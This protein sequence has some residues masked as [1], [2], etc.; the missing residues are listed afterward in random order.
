MTTPSGSLSQKT[1]ERRTQKAWPWIFEK[2]HDRE[3]RRQLFLYEGPEEELNLNNDGAG[4]NFKYRAER[5]K[6]RREKMH[7]GRIR[8]SSWYKC[9]D[10]QSEKIFYL[11]KKTN[12]SSYN[13]P[14][15]L[16]KEEMVYWEW[17]EHFHEENG[18]FFYI[19]QVTGKSIWRVPCDIDEELVE[20][21]VKRKARELASERVCQ[22]LSSA[23]IELCDNVRFEPIDIKIGAK[24]SSKWSK[25]LFN[26][27]DCYFVLEGTIDK[28]FDRPPILPSQQDVLTEW[29]EILDDNTGIFF[30]VHRVYPFLSIWKVP[31]DIDLA[32]VIKVFSQD[33]VFKMIRDCLSSIEVEQISISGDKSSL[34]GKVASRDE[35]AVSNGEE[36]GID[37]LTEEYELKEAKEEEDTYGEEWEENEDYRWF[38][39]KKVYDQHIA[40]LEGRSCETD[41]TVS[42]ISTE[43]S[44]LSQSENG[45]NL[46]I[47]VVKSKIPRS[48]KFSYS[49]TALN[50]WHFGM[51]AMHIYKLQTHKTRQIMDISKWKKQ[52]VNKKTENF[53]RKLG[54]SLADNHSLRGLYAKGVKDPSRFVKDEDGKLVNLDEKY[55]FDE[56]CIELLFSDS[57]AF[58]DTLTFLDLSYNL[59][60]ERGS[61]ILFRS[62]KVNSRLYELDLT[63]CGIVAQA[64]TTIMKALAENSSLG[65]LILR[66]NLLQDDGAIAIFQALVRNHSLRHLDVA[67]NKIGKK[68]IMELGQAI[69]RNT[70]LQ[71]LRLEGNPWLHELNEPI[72]NRQVRNHTKITVK[73][74]DEDTSEHELIRSVL[75]CLVGAVGREDDA[76]LSSSKTESLFHYYRVALTEGDDSVFLLN[77]KE[78]PGK[79]FDPLEQIP[80]QIKILV[81]LM[82]D[83]V[84]RF[85]ENCEPEVVSTL[86]CIVD[87]VV[88]YD[89]GLKEMRKIENIHLE[90]T[91]VPEI[92]RLFTF[93]DIECMSET[94]VEEHDID[95]T[96]LIN[97][98]SDQLEEH[99]EGIKQLGNEMEPLK[100]EDYKNKYVPS[101]SNEVN[102]ARCFDVLI[103][104]E[105]CK[106]LL[107]E[108]VSLHPFLEIKKYEKIFMSHFKREC[109]TREEFFEFAMVILQ[110]NEEGKKDAYNQHD[111]YL[112]KVSWNEMSDVEKV[113]S[114]ILA[115]REITI[116]LDALT[117]T[118]AWTDTSESENG[119]LEL[120]KTA[121]QK[122]DMAQRRARAQK[123]RDLI[124]L[125]K[126][127]VQN[128]YPFNL[129]CE[130]FRHYEENTANWGVLEC[131]GVERLVRF[132]QK[133][134]LRRLKECAPV[135]GCVA[136]GVAQYHGELLAQEEENER[137]IEEGNPVPLLE[138]DNPSEEELMFK[139]YHSFLDGQEEVQDDNE[140]LDEIDESPKLLINILQAKGLADADF[141]GLSDPFVVVIVDDQ[142]IARTRV[143][144]NNLNPVFEEVFEHPVD[145]NFYRSWVRFEVYDDDLVGEDE[146]LGMINFNGSEILSMCGNS[147]K[148]FSLKGMRGKPTTYVQGRLKLLFNIIGDG[149]SKHKTA[150]RVE[151]FDLPFVD[152]THLDYLLYGVRRS[153]LE[154][155][156]V[157][158]YGW[159]HVRRLMGYRNSEEPEVILDK[160][161][162]N[163]ALCGVFE[164]AEEYNCT[165]YNFHEAKLHRVENAIVFKTLSFNK[166]VESL[167]MSGNDLLHDAILDITWLWTVSSSL[168]YVDMT[169]CNFSGGALAHDSIAAMSSAIQSTGRP[170][171]IKF[172]KKALEVQDIYRGVGWADGAGSK[173]LPMKLSNQGDGI[174]KMEDLLLGSIIIASK[175]LNL[176][177]VNNIDIDGLTTVDHGKRKLV[178]HES[179][180]IAERMASDNTVTFLNLESCLI[181][182]LSYTTMPAST[183]TILPSDG[184]WGGKVILG[185]PASA[186]LAD[187]L[188]DNT[189]LTELNLSNCGIQT[190]R[191]FKNLLKDNK[192]LRTIDLSNNPLGEEAAPIAEGISLNE[193][194]LT[195]TMSHC[196]LTTRVM[197]SF[198]ESLSTNKSM[199]ALNIPFNGITRYGAAAIS[200]GLK[201][202][203]GLLKLNMKNCNIGSAGAI[204]IAEMLEV[205]K[206]LTD[207]N[208]GGDPMGE[209]GGA[210][211]QQGALALATMLRKNTT[212]KALHLP[213]SGVQPFGAIYICQSLQFNTTL[214]TLDISG[215]LPEHIAHRQPP[216]PIFHNFGDESDDDEEEMS[217]LSLAEK[218]R[219]SEEAMIRQQEKVRLMSRLRGV[220]GFDGRILAEGA[221]GVKDMLELNS[222]LTELDISHNNIGNEG[223]KLICEGLEVNTGLAGIDL[224]D[225]NVN[226]Q[227]ARHMIKALDARKE[228]NTSLRYIVLRGAEIGNENILKIQSAAM[229]QFVTIW[230]YDS[231]HLFYMQDRDDDPEKD[232]REV[233]EKIQERQEIL[234]GMSQY[235]MYHEDFPYCCRMCGIKDNFEKI[236]NVEKKEKLQFALESGNQKL[237]D[238]LLDNVEVEKHIDD[239]EKEKAEIRDKRQ[240]GILDD[241]E[242]P[243]GVKKP[244]RADNAVK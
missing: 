141:V 187:R 143:I 123:R 36:N 190:S 150:C 23:V 29:T 238:R 16:P 13:R 198:G 154:K 229:R 131:L 215:P 113:Y 47:D 162:E 148:Y 114:N 1:R 65:K 221:R 136:D 178:Y 170:V 137:L 104:D 63:N 40:M 181:D 138:E 164:E 105:R 225:E 232:V 183:E 35:T 6:A 10:Q 26:D 224:S 236:E 165:K 20:I 209:M 92:D 149:G 44:R 22:A 218:A 129:E 103:A 84:V 125:A 208:I 118:V 199:T 188:R 151:D 2:K 210:V 201:H 76:S 8:Q 174:N 73:E 56:D 14:D 78:V 167:D 110:L 99:V 239:A 163:A 230:A 106:V 172:G 91:P 27:E 43:T 80:H 71:E 112:A 24:R 233:E 31:L 175:S 75:A 70:G 19:N 45:Q 79:A 68:A 121:K 81:D 202:N 200:E 18:R 147:S 69:R 241:D 101:Y 211:E 64:G 235:L 158:N 234:K 132:E 161:R 213:C 42:Q 11:D 38:R 93:L 107:E 97:I 176:S 4:G 15:E 85:H 30:Y 98:D 61:V 53:Y 134:E 89:K 28:V 195:L 83:S 66:N 169:M 130:S 9:Y 160:N 146:F 219:A 100:I 124:Q 96:K 139:Y 87:T 244:K 37:E 57:L 222:T 111:G 48:D 32:A 67:N 217:M 5:R 127:V 94:E 194:L 90:K 50:F 179:I 193:T 126:D 223:F 77:R 220:P 74:G 207:V 216:E 135:I 72:V 204:S 33:L 58:N 82:C 142:E 51:K 228:D 243:G 192:I 59:L 46:T 120:E 240:K 49:D 155:L 159:L 237:L 116:V 109:L 227:C 180:Y 186:I 54:Q 156:Q 119:L 197:E 7:K 206:T 196:D 95:G 168:L 62:I 182:K 128:A 86:Q 21:V 39:M 55:C 153:V 203:E 60:G 189:R 133:K 171:Q 41:S 88:W 205:N 117:F 173:V 52:I 177:S 214:V 166:A 185:L 12:L 212:L 34:D 140:E 3:Q 152:D 108:L 184:I 231:N 226:E 102:T 25:H 115:T 144:D 191:L 145:K 242:L 157:G 17:E 122:Y